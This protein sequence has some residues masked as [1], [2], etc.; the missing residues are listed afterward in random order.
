MRKLNPPTHQTRVVKVI[1]PVVDIP[2]HKG[3]WRLEDEREEYEEWISPTAIVRS[4]AD[5]IT[6]R[7]PT[8]KQ[9]IGAKPAGF[10][11]AQRAEGEW[12]FKQF[13]PHYNRKW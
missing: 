12:K 2:G 10:F 7:M 6:G 13:L 5:P 1:R 3:E 11:R 9:C 8:V 4:I